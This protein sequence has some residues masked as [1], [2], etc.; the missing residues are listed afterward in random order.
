MV[1]PC[2]SNTSRCGPVRWETR[3][4][5]TCGRRRGSLW[6]MRKYLSWTLALAGLAFT[7]GAGRAAAAEGRAVA[8]TFDDL[9]GPPGSLVANDVAA[10]REN[11]RK[12]LASFAELQVPVVGFVNEGKL[13]VEGEP[14]ADTEARIAVLQTWV[15]AGLRARQPHLLAPEPEPHAPRGVRGGRRPGRARDAAPPR[16]Q[17]DEAPLLPPSLPPGGARTRQAAG[18]RG[19]PEGTRLHGGTGDDRQRRL[20]L[21]SDLRRG[22][23][24][25]RPEGRS[26]DRSRLRALHGHR[27]LVRRGASRAASPDARSPRF[28]WSTR[29]P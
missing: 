21:R 20:R 22:A 9:P 17:G 12:L 25:W 23:P 19:L 15:D 7:A 11:T 6:P 2:E 10:L 24:P 13:F 3:G 28:S 29:A 18:L 5:E 16:G 8:V 27:R 4:Q 14:P 26:A 1:E